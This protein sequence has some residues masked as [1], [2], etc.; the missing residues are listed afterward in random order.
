MDLTPGL[1]TESNLTQKKSFIMTWLTVMLTTL[2]VTSLAN[3]VNAQYEYRH[4]IR[5]MELPSFYFQPVEFDAVSYPSDIAAGPGVTEDIVSGL[6]INPANAPVPLTYDYIAVDFNSRV[7][8]PSYRSIPNLYDTPDFSPAAGDSRITT[9]FPGSYSDY[10][11]HSLEKQL[12]RPVLSITYLGRP[13]T[14]GMQNTMIGLSYQLIRSKESYYPSD[15]PFAVGFT[16]GDGPEVPGNSQFMP[17]R[18]SVVFRDEMTRTGH[19]LSLYIIRMASA[20]TRVGL[21]VSGMLNKSDGFFSDGYS[22]QHDL[23]TQP[24]F[25][26]DTD[27]IRSQ[28]YKHLDV[29]IGL[30]Q[31]YSE[32]LL[33]GWSAG[34]LSVGSDHQQSTWYRQTGDQTRQLPP[35]R[36]RDNREEQYLMDI[37]QS[38]ESF[39]SG[40]NV[41]YHFTDRSSVMGHYRFLYS[42]TDAAATGSWVFQLHRQDTGLAVTRPDVLGYQRNRELTDESGSLNQQH[43]RLYAALH[44]REWERFLIYLGAQ[45]VWH[46]WSYD[47]DI[48][49]RVDIIWNNIND[50]ESHIYE[51]LAYGWIGRN[52]WRSITVPTQFRIRL[53]DSMQL[54]AG[55][56]LSLSDHNVTEEGDYRLFGTPAILSADDEYSRESTRVDSYAGLLLHPSNLLRIELLG[57][58]VNHDR[59]A[60]EWFRPDFGIRVMLFP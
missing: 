36:F 42:W 51:L 12:D 49:D 59:R 19:Q 43:Q 3:T 11:G 52:T 60:T 40:P 20:R 39:Y 33:M 25:N 1:M 26:F 44:F 4:P 55:G 48:D 30:Q 23:V 53:T 46:R 16:P 35:G 9:G 45:L 22:V 10:F 14:V 34:L 56:Q 21:R 5:G 37:E 31:Q 8:V 13:Q 2:L 15:S 18:S 58:V 50:E 6:F 7:T 17:A 29:Q 32:N 27:Q 47:T 54:L 38:G 41:I 57:S 28:G 24:Y